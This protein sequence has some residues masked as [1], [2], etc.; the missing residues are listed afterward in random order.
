MQR[1]CGV[2]EV[3]SLY[4]ESNEAFVMA[5]GKGRPCVGQMNAVER[6][7]RTRSTPSQRTGAS[8]G[9]VDPTKTC[10]REGLLTLGQRSN[11]TILSHDSLRVGAEETGRSYG[12]RDLYQQ[13]HLVKAPGIHIPRLR[14]TH[15]VHGDLTELTDLGAELLDR[16]PM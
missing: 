12:A 14:R 16:R 5:G 8:R 2:V 11:G 15:T 1:V 13:D 9:D 7:G 10:S 6:E 3:A 4:S